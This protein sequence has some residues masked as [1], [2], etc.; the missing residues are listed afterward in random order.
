[1]EAK[2]VISLLFDERV[3]EFALAYACMHRRTGQDPWRMGEGGN[4]M[5]LHIVVDT[6]KNG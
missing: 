3:G 6:V 1:M 4:R 5:F 2:L